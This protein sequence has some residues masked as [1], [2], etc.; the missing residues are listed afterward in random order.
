M[1]GCMRASLTGG[2]MPRCGS[3]RSSP[4]VTASAT[5]PSPTTNSFRRKTDNADLPPRVP[6]RTR[7]EEGRVVKKAMHLSCS[8]GW[9]RPP[10]ATPW[11]AVVGLPPR[12]EIVYAIGELSGTL[13]PVP[14]LA[15]G[16][17]GRR[18]KP[19][20]T[21][22]AEGR[23][24]PG[25]RSCTVRAGLL[26]TSPSVL[27]RNPAASLRPC[28]VRRRATSP[29]PV[30]RREWRQVNCRAARAARPCAAR[31]RRCRL[32]GVWPGGGGDLVA[33]LRQGVD[34]AVPG[35]VR[36]RFHEALR[37]VAEREVLGSPGPVPRRPRLAGD[38]LDPGADRDLQCVDPKGVPVQ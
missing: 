36:H 9:D 38:R 19:Q 26:W 16:S 18:S 10:S 8:D 11:R 12:N 24:Q 22:T 37:G 23:S 27:Q 2:R 34:R 15:L 4:A 21:A 31:P 17:P 28:R 35:V 20:V 33:Q 32:W 30:E 7:R 14:A 5:M 13:T 25:L 3:S 1:T 29:G 6:H